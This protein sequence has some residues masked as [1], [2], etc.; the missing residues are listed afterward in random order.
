MKSVE[1]WPSFSEK[2]FKDYRIFIHV[3][4][5]GARADNHRGQIYIVTKSVCYFEHIL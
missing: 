2:I 5:K 4:S 1:N 3:Y